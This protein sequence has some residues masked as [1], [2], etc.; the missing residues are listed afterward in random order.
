MSTTSQCTVPSPLMTPFAKCDAVAAPSV[1]SPELMSVPSMTSSATSAPE[2]AQMMDTVKA[3]IKNINEIIDL[4][5]HPATVKPKL[6]DCIYSLAVVR[7]FK[8]RCIECDHS[9]ENA[10]ATASAWLFSVSTR[11]A[12]VNKDLA[13]VQGRLAGIEEKIVKN[14]QAIG[15]SIKDISSSV[16]DMQDQDMLGGKLGP[17]QDDT[18]AR[19]FTLSFC[20]S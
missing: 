9:L 2:Y 16:P 13:Q 10:S 8:I 7:A 11:L 19:T 18:Q 15:Q 17:E 5:E 14:L 20:V 6:S 1:Q 12:G 4:L 3:A